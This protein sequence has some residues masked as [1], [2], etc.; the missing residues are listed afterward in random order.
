M[1][2]WIP[3]RGAAPCKHTKKTRSLPGGAYSLRPTKFCV[4]DIRGWQWEGGGRGER[5]CDKHRCVP[6]RTAFLY[7]ALSADCRG[8]G[9]FHLM[10][11][12][13]RRQQET[14]QRNI[15]WNRYLRQD[16]EWIKCH[17]LLPQAVLGCLGKIW[18]MRSRK[19]F[20]MGICWSSFHSSPLKKRLHPY[21]PFLSLDYHNCP[22]NLPWSPIN[23]GGRVWW[24]LLSP[25]CTQQ[26]RCSCVWGTGSNSSG[27]NEWEQ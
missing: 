20:I 8:R 7:C 25:N 12:M 18:F 13:D 19:Y 2:D 14:V 15:V 16:N 10:G 3:G 4:S 17:F 9:G 5:W 1:K 23:V 27:P 26:Q 24:F 11:S 21:F 6:W 22:Q